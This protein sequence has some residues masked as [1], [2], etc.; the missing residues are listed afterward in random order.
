METK[1]STFLKTLTNYELQVFYYYRYTEFL[2]ES[3]ALIHAELRK[4]NLQ[5]NSTLKPAKLASIGGDIAPQCKICGSTNFIYQ[6]KTEIKVGKFA[7]NETN[8]Y[9]SKCRLCNNIA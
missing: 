9:E 8:Y 3:Q 4:R 2:P 5:F 1:L 7:Q 6:I